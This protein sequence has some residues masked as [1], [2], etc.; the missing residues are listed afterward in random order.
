MYPNRAE[1]KRA[2]FHYIEMVYNP[3]R[4]HTKNGRMSPNDFERKYFKQIEGV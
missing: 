4:R 1:A 2:V 3:T